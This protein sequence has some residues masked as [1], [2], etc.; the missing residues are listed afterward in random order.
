M[1]HIDAR[2]LKTKEAVTLDHLSLSNVEWAEESVSV[3][4][5]GL[6]AASEWFTLAVGRPTGEDC[7]SK[8]RYVKPIEP[9][10]NFVF[11]DLFGFGCHCDGFTTDKIM[12]VTW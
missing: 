1:L 12:K 3:E 9:Y 7:M 10:H 8:V 4:D 11:E 6:V 5:V 2:M